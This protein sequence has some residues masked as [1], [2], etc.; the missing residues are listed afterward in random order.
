MNPIKRKLTHSKDKTLIY[1]AS[2]ASWY[3]R[4]FVWVFSEQFYKFNLIDRN[5][6]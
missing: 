2:L 1:A 3:L 5:Y 6:T 4:D